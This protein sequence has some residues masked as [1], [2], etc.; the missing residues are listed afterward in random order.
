MSFLNEED[1]ENISIEWFKE[2]GY[3]YA[4]GPDIAPDGSTPERDDLRQVYLI[5]RLRT[6][7]I[8]LNPEVPN[9]TIESA[10]LQITN[11]SIPG[12]VSCNRQLHQWITMGFLVSY[13]NGDEE[14]NIRLK[15]IDFEEPSENDFLVVN[16]LKVAGPKYN[17]IPDI[18]AYINGIPIAVIELKNPADENTDI[19]DAYNQLQTYK[20][21]IPDLFSSNILLV[22]S[23]GTY[24]KVGSLS[25]NEERFQRWRVIEKEQDLDPLGNFRELETLVRGLFDQKRLLDFIRS[26]CL[27]EEDGEIIKKIAAYHQFYAVNNAIE[28]VVEASSSGGDRRGGVVW[29]TQGAG[30]SIE[31]ACLAGKLLTDE[32]LQNPTLIFVTDRNDLDGQL[33]G[34]FAGSGGLLGESPK[35]AETKDDL[36]KLLEDIPSGG[37]IFTTIQKFAKKKEE[38]KFPQLTSREN[39][40]VICD[41]A[42]RSQYGFKARI[43]SKTGE[44]KYGLARGLRDA[45]PNATFLAFTGTPISFADKNTQSVFG[46]YISIYDIQQAVEDKATVPIYYESRQAKLELKKDAIPIIDSREEEIFASEDELPENYKKKSKWAALEKLVGSPPRLKQI[47]QDLVKHYEKRCEIQPGKALVVGMSREICAS[48]YKE[49]IAIKPEWEDSSHMR[50]SI[51]VVMTAKASDKFELQK[52][53]TN[54]Q[55]RD[56]LA[57]RFKDPNDPLKIVLV[58]NMWLTGFDAPCLATMYI[59]KPMKGANL[60]QAIAR[61]NR[62]FKDKPGG[63][64][65][66]YIGFSPQLKEALAT[67][68]GDRGRGEPALDIEEALL[69]LKEQIQIAHDLLFPVEWENFSEKGKAFELIPNCLEKILSIENGKQRFCDAV[70]RMTKAFSLCSSTD[71]ANQFSEKVA[72]LNAVRA[73]LIK[74]SRSG[75]TP[76]EGVD[77][78][79]QQLLSESLVAQGVTDIFKVAGLKNPDISILSNAFLE[80]VYKIPQKNLAVELLEKL[81]KDEV[82]SKFRTNLV[83]QKRFSEMLKATLNKY[84]NRAIEA[85]QVIEELIEMAKKFRE[86]LEKGI[87]LGLSSAERSFYDALAENPSAQQLMEEKV[88]ANMAKELAEIIRRDANIDWQYKDNVRAK[89]RIKIKTLLKRYKYPPDEQ[90]T[91]IETVLQQAETLGEELVAS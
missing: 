82:K 84:E 13:L 81:I 90:V 48:L 2:I 52:H 22:I 46:H 38:H 39:I 75:G 35:Q 17:R 40:I 8:R 56:D 61:V 12:L 15:I 68:T 91:A 77:Y 36:R 41:E 24:A 42:H 26:F 18:V 55:Q 5:D 70:L 34:V 32:R 80:E 29:H 69:I 14:K 58:R 86:D 54:K 72:F 63:L 50:G 88:L 9:K 85:A 33:F 74:D 25:A 7:L 73:P 83:K 89:L 31:M 3:A 60:A 51:K 47:A 87:S 59:D 71:E 67:Y 53:N 79:L 62:V 21:N 57:K 66:D 19:W 37:I 64:I 43:D 78:K 65:V 45:L 27:F 4:H 49:I 16:Q 10:I 44:I 20:D 28:R 6:A 1:L 11:P 30:K 76:T 23:D